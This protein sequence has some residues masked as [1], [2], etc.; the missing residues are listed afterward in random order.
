MTRVDGRRIDE[1]RP[2]TFELGIQPAT[3]GSV[4]LRWGNTHIICSG[5]IEE[6]VPP[7]RYDSGGGWL[8]AEY[9]MLP[10]SSGE[11]IRRSRSGPSG[12]TAEIQRLIGRSLRSVFDLSQRGQRT[13]RIDCDVLNADGGTRCASITAAYV[14]GCLALAKISEV[15]G[16]KLV[17]PPNVAGVSVGECNG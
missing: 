15:D 6:R 10:G 11:R 14:V 5:S 2:I 12:R 16:K 13:L 4:L 7:H 3:A 1:L 9:A 8:T 17:L